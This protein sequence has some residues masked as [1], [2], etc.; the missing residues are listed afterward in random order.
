MTPHQH[1][2]LEHEFDLWL[3]DAYEHKSTTW[4]SHPWRHLGAWIRQHVHGHFFGDDS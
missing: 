2:S 1:F 3:Y 4:N